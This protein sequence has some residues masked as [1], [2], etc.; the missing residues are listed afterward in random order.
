LPATTTTL[1]CKCHRQP[2][3]LFATKSMSIHNF[4][5]VGTCSTRNASSQVYKLLLELPSVLSIILQC[6]QPFLQFQPM[7][8]R[9]HVLLR[10]LQVAQCRLIHRCSNE[11][12]ASHGH[13]V[14]SVWVRM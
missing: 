5:L 12:G 10:R 6:S 9:S 8:T 2:S 7:K 13:D 11:S 4:D 1:R 14:F 3:V